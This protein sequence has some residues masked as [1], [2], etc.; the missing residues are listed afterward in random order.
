MTNNDQ[1]DVIDFSAYRQLQ[2]CLISDTHGQIAPEVINLANQS[3]IV[4]HAGDI[5]GAS[6][7]R[8]LTPKLD[9]VIG[10]RGNNDFSATWKPEDQKLL[11]DLPE[12][13]IVRVCGGDIAIE[14]GHRVPRIEV[15]HYSLAYK[16][17]N[18]RMVVFGHTHVQRA[19]VDSLPWLVNPGAA[20]LVRN[21]GGPS[22]SILKIQD[23][24]WT[25]EQCKFSS[26]K[27]AG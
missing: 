23:I 12:S 17:P 3:D 18:V 5:M 22:C 25:L 11:H 16:Y 7:L 4:L 24:D 20:G 15:D 8:T 14:H 9:S 6:V 1:I 13:V 27:K 26:V 21:H 2:V 10:V 19:D